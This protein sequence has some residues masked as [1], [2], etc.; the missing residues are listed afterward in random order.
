LELFVPQLGGV[1][2]PFFR[3]GPVR[4]LDDAKTC[5]TA[6]YAAFFRGMLERGFYLPPAQFEAAF[7]SAAHTDADIG[8]FIAAVKEVIKGM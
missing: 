4:N 7:I 1:F 5:D 6:A 8:V 2:T 3:R